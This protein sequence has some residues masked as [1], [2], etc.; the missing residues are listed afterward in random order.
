MIL[1]IIE[2]NGNAIE[3]HRQIVCVFEVMIIALVKLHCYSLASFFSLGW[4]KAKL[5]K[6]NSKERKL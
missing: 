3:C 5:S 4:N 1:I 2:M 6:M